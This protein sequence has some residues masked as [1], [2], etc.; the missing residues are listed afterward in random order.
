MALKNPLAQGGIMTVAPDEMTIYA[1][2]PEI[3]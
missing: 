1:I 3:A 2:C